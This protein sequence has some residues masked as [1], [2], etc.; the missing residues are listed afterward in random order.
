MRYQGSSLG[1]EMSGRPKS[2]SDVRQSRTVR[3]PNG[4]EPHGDG[5]LVVVRDRESR[6]HGEG[7]QVDR[8]GRERGSRNGQSRPSETPAAGE[9][10]AAKV[11][12]AER[13]AE[14]LTQSGETRRDVS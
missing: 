13:D 6:S 9:P 10:C 4:R 7:G 1:V 14:S 3:S 12:S 11:A 5:A 2:R 8:S